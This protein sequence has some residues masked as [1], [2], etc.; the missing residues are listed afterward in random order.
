MPETIPRPL[1]DTLRILRDLLEDL[2]V[3]AP[4]GGSCGLLLQ[5]VAIARAP[6]DIDLYADAL[7]AERIDQRLR[8]FAT[9]RPKRD[10][11]GLYRSLLSHYRIGETTIELV[12]DFRVRSGSSVYDVRL[13]GGLAPYCPRVTVA[14]M[15]WTV[16]PLAHE[17]TFNVLRGRPDRTG[18]IASVMRKSWQ[19]HREA[20]RWIIANN[21]LSDVHLS[22]MAALLPELADQRPDR[23]D[24]RTDRS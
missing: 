22:Q 23:S 12:G 6:R 4:L 19:S 11:S 1:M 8:D 15:E 10:E 16:M 21:A 17:L 18:P 9:D 20:V 2:Q 7:W 3:R 13:D 24:G 5:K 14:D